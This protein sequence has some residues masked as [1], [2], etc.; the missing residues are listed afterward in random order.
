MN[1]V[2]PWM[3]KYFGV[4]SRPQTYLNLVYL[5]LS[6]PL[7]ILY[8]TFL[9]TGVSLGLP[10]IFFLVG[11]I[12][13]AAVVTVS[14]HMVSFERSMAISLLH[15]KIP[16]MSNEVS[17]PGT[18]WQRVRNT[19]VNPV[20][21]KGLL[22]LLCKFPLGIINFVLVISILALVLVLLAAPF[23]YP[24]ATYDLGFT[25]VNSLTEALLLTITGLLITPSGFHLLNYL[26][27]IQGEFARVMLGQYMSGSV[28]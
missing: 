26:A 4:V 17:Q 18:F 6:F 2:N 28:Q 22:F 20:T 10:L 7:G 8:F 15:I 12:I 13:L 1:D 5:L 16:P 27:R 21:W 19:L 14:W 23:I 11:V 25:V 3:R 24:W 9:V